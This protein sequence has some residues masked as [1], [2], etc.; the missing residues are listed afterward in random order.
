MSLTT[1]LQFGDNGF[2]RYSREYLVSEYKCRV[3]RR[4]NEARPDGNARCEH[5]ELTVIAPGKE[6]LNLIEWYVG[7]ASMSGRILIE[8][9]G[10]ARDQT[11]EWR[12]VLFENGICYSIAEEYHIDQQ[13]RRALRLGIAVENLTVD[14]IIFNAK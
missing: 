14:D 13:S 3:L 9:P 10:T 4:H 6:D 2:R 12:E 5:I 1:K 8:I 7:Q 11:T